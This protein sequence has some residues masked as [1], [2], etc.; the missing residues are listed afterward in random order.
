MS[1]IY[2][3]LNNNFLMK[4]DHV[5]LRDIRISLRYGLAKL[6][7]PPIHTLGCREGLGEKSSVK[8]LP[9]TSKEHLR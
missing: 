6:S 7:L 3:A 8:I 1:E 4:Q 5:S 9:G 2:M